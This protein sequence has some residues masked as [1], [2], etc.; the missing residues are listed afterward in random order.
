M[1]QLGM[2]IREPCDLSLWSYL[3]RA[4]IR[5]LEKRGTLAELHAKLRSGINKCLSKPISLLTT[6]K[7]IGGNMDIISKINL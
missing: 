2:H 6:L 5:L 3:V 4:V 1:S 7:Y